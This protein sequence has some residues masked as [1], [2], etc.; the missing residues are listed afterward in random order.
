[1]KIDGSLV[2]RSFVQHFNL[3]G[4]VEMDKYL[5]TKEALNIINDDKHRLPIHCLLKS[6]CSMTFEADYVSLASFLCVSWE[7]YCTQLP[8]RVQKTH[9]SSLESLEHTSREKR[10]PYME[11]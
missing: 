6:S 4:P 8:T 10:R 11:G 1:M 3:Y 2:K 7:T 9:F 5:I